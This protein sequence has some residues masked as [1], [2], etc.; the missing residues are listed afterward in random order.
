M[1]NYGIFTNFGVLQEL[2]QKGEISSKKE[3]KNNNCS[4]LCRNRVQCVATNV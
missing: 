1:P 4:S 2:I 3:E